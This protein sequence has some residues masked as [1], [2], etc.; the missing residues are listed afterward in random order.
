MKQYSTYPVIDILEASF[1]AYRTNGNTIVRESMFDLEAVG[2]E[3][4]LTKIPN[5]QLINEYLENKSSLKITHDDRDYASMAIQ[6]IDHERTLKLLR[7]ENTTEFVDGIIKE[8]KE[9]QSNK[10]KL[11]LW[12]PEIFFR[13]SEKE[14]F[15]EAILQSDYV[16][17]IGDK[18]TVDVEVI[19][20][21][22]ISRLS[23]WIVTTKNKDNNVIQ[24]FTAKDECTVSGKYYGI[25]SKLEENLYLRGAKTTMLNRVKFLDKF[26][27]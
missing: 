6:T 27:F 19:N 23:C 26:P 1:C 25:V 8:G 16:G 2:E 12:I 18:L 3:K 11:L 10:I 14:Q 15:E 7:G 17:K 21:K 9:E 24:W 5:V 4:V 13:I 22:Y 20:K